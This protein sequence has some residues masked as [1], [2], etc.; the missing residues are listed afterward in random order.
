MFETLTGEHRALQGSKQVNSR[1]PGMGRVA[2]KAFLQ[3][4]TANGQSRA[5]P[6]EREMWAA[7]F[8]P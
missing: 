2:G 5:P 1:E 8:R 6:P 4:P 3:R 7:E